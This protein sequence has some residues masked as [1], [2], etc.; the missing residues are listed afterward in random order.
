MNYFPG[1]SRPSVPMP[2]HR[3]PCRQVR[4]AG[5]SSTDFPLRHRFHI[6]GS[7]AF[8]LWGRES[9]D[10]RHPYPGFVDPHRVYPGGLLA[11]ALTETSD[12]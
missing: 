5:P 4:W 9:I 10:G 12:K 6:D 3:V 11:F 7:T 8:A 2:R 1:R